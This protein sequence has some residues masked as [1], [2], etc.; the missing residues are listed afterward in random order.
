M[1]EN[2]NFAQPE[3]LWL[4]ALPLLILVAY[5]FR[6]R[7]RPALSSTMF[8]L[9][10]LREEKSTGHKFGKL[11]RRLSLLF[12][13]LSSVSICCLLAGPILNLPRKNKQLAIVFD[14]SASMYA[15]HEKAKTRALSLI[16]QTADSGDT[17]VLDQVSL[18]DSHKSSRPFFRGNQR[19]K[20]EKAISDWLPSAAEG[21]ESLAIAAAKKEVGEHGRVFYITDRAQPS[22]NEVIQIN[23]G[24][25]LENIALFAPQVTIEDKRWGWQAEVGNFSNRV[26]K[27]GWIARSNDGE[28]ISRG[29]NELLLDSKLTISGTVPTKI[30]EISLSLGEPEGEPL[31]DDFPLDNAL[32]IIKP[33]S[34][35]IRLYVSVAK[36]HQQLLKRLLAVIPESAFVG[37]IT[38]ADLAFVSDNEELPATYSKSSVIFHDAGSEPSQKHPLATAGHTGIVSSDH[39]LISGLSWE[40]LTPRDIALREG[41][42]ENHPKIVLLAKDNIALLELEKSGS[43]EKL[44][45][46]FDVAENGTLPQPAIVVLLHRFIESVRQTA[47]GPGSQNYPLLQLDRALITASKVKFKPLLEFPGYNSTQDHF[48]R[49]YTGFIDFIANNG[50][51]MKA[52]YY[53]EKIAESD[54]RDSGNASAK[55]A[56]PIAENNL[57]PNPAVF[58]SDEPERS[59]VEIM[60]D[61]LIAGGII[62]G[63]FVFLVLAWWSDESRISRKMPVGGADVGGA[64]V[65]G[66]DVG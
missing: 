21:R 50:Q 31:K 30:A 57:L 17:G 36:S 62:T 42:N 37:S 5:L 12:F 61:G 13:L 4:L 14:G 3:A 15:F 35:K 19:I 26:R 9:A 28:I 2:F 53:N 34:A 32:A 38:E 48:A 64:D 51:Q 24:R 45:F 11:D 29:Q 59:V 52:A 8:L 46:N 63:I 33:K 16:S 6:R 18:Y 49:G 60:T 54:F 20:L 23:I 65:G 66:P 40:T 27:I 41:N 39:Y 43:G 7:A 10:E 58:S 56:H 25:P 55:H 1:S 47:F 44:T 22:V